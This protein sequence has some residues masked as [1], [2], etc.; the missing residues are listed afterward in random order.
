MSLAAYN[1]ELKRRSFHCAD[2]DGAKAEQMLFSRR[3][4]DDDDRSDFPGDDDV[5]L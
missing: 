4:E 5:T 3:V 2:D 1:W